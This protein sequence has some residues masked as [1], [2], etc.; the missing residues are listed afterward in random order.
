MNVIFGSATGLTATGNERSVTAAGRFLNEPVSAG[1]VLGI[2]G[3]VGQADG[4]H[5]HE[6]TGIPNDP[7]NPI[8]SA[9]F[10]IGY[11]LDPVICGIPGQTFVA[12]QTYTADDC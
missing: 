12:G 9:G 7:G 4:R 1:T 11:N 5:L 10:L 6:E 8:D 2:E 3:D